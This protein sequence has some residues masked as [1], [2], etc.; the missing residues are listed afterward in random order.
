M[1]KEL[2]RTAKHRTGNGKRTQSP[3]YLIGIDEAGR[4]PLAGPV[5]V[6]AFA[7]RDP[8]VLR[9]FRGVK[10]S[11]QLSAK[12]REV[13]FASIRTA[14]KD[15]DSGILYSVSFAHPE[16]I[17]SKGLTVSIY[18]AINS[19]LRKLER[20]DEKCREAEIRLD[21]LLHASER[22]ADQRTII[23]GD[24]SEPVIALASICAKV[25]RDKRM[26]KFAREFPQYGF[27]IHKGYGTKAHYDA[28]KKHG[29]TPIHRRRFL[30]GIV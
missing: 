1:K 27:D 18:H 3:R 7:I 24:E 25:M 5:S 11:K 13:W 6:G 30:K 21:G 29:I 19:C 28:I 15:A 4:G 10:E 12:Q 17:D 22:Y 2:A 8:K 23:G 16:T 26:V 14:A 9:A 20:M